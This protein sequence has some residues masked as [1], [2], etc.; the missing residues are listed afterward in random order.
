MI[1]AGTDAP[2]T[3]AP[4]VPTSLGSTDETVAAEQKGFT[5]L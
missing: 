5:V 3:T 4:G 1:W 2:W